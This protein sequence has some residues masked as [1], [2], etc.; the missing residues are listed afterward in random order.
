MITPRKVGLPLNKDVIRG[1]KA[2]EVVELYGTVYTARDAAHKK[3]VD[4]LKN[5]G[6]IPLK[7]KGAV[8]YYCG[9]TP[10]LKGKLIGSCG[11]TTSGRMDE[12]TPLLLSRGIAAVIGKGRRSDKTKSAFKKYGAVYFIAVGGC[13]ALYSRCIKKC[14]VVAYPELGTE[15][16]RELVIEKFPVVVGI[17]PGRRDITDK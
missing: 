10:A 1:L 15:A 14:R 4:T 8:L 7:L 2:G 11:P 17:T 13:G 9:P 16:V 3:L 12:Y 6:R 5:G